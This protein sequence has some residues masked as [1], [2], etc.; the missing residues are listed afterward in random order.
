MEAYSRCSGKRTDL[1]KAVDGDVSG[2]GDTCL[3]EKTV[4]KLSVV[5]SACWKFSRWGGKGR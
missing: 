4:R 1:P 3:L 2:W 5:E